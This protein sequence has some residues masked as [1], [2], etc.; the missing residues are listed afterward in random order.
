[1]NINQKTHSVNTNTAS[2][3]TLVI[4]FS[5]IFHTKAEE[6]KAEN[7]KY[8]ETFFIFNSLRGS[9]NAAIFKDFMDYLKKLFVYLGLK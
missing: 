4:K 1:M 8:K 7:R 6:R 5:R 9:S 3:F 2:S